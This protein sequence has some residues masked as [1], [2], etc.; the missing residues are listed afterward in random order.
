[1]ILSPCYSASK[2]SFFTSLYLSLLL[3]FLFIPFFLSVFEFSFQGRREVMLTLEHIFDRLDELWALE[4]ESSSEEPCPE[5]L[6]SRYFRTD[7]TAE[8]RITTKKRAPGTR[9]RENS[10]LAGHSAVLAVRRSARPLKVA[11]TLDWVRIDNFTVDQSKY[12][13]ETRSFLAAA[14]GL[15]AHGAPSKAH[16][17]PA[18]SEGLGRPNESLRARTCLDFTTR[19]SREGCLRGSTGL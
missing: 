1:L 10:T 2:L 18:P 7:W 3:L 4:V 15:G 5:W 12:S 9:Q 8:A 17:R 6:L 11:R 13:L 19:A 16:G 14:A